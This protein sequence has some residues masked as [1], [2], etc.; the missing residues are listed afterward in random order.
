MLMWVMRSLILGTFF[1][2]PL[3]IT[4]N[5]YLT[6]DIYLI[7][8]NEYFMSL[9]VSIFPIFLFNIFTFAYFELL[10]QQFDIDVNH[11]ELIAQDDVNQIM[12]NLMSQK[13]QIDL[14][15]LDTKYQEQDGNLEPYITLRGHTGPLLS[16]T[17]SISENDR[18]LFTAGTEGCIR[19]WNL[20][21][22]SEVNFYGDTQEGKNYCIGTW[23]VGE[24]D[25]QWDI[26]HHPFQDLLLS[27]SANK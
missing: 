3:L 8:E 13:Y 20:P 15:D 25:V 22:P 4:P 19:V 17:G 5:Y 16:V 18:L 12:W 24:E 21:A 26:K 27:V 9:F 11:F 23:Q 10:C 1:I 14:N 6:E 2:L 7:G